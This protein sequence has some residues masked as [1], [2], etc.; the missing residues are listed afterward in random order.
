MIA[1]DA[2]GFVSTPRGIGTRDPA[3]TGGSS[4]PSKK[5][6]MIHPRLPPRTAPPMAGPPRMPPPRP[7]PRPTIPLLSVPAGATAPPSAEA[8]RVAQATPPVHELGRPSD[9]LALLQR[10]CEYL[11]NLGRRHATALADADASIAALRVALHAVESAVGM[12]GRVL[13]PTTEFVSREDSVEVAARVPRARA[14][15][16]P[17]VVVHVTYPMQT[18]QD[19]QRTLVCMRRVNVDVDTAEV[20]MSWI[21]V[22]ERDSDTRF[23]GE[24]AVV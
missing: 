7:G 8:A 21:V 22:Y 13:V 12:R 23:V 6:A 4:N 11:E 18:L 20:T 10:R 14:V 15:V 17:G 24:F 5:G 16:A 19:G 2:F 1:H 9:T 3:F